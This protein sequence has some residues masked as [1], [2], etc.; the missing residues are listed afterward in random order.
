[1]YRIT[2]FDNGRIVAFL[3]FEKL[4]AEKVE[5]FLEVFKEEDYRMMVALHGERH[6]H[7]WAGEADE[8]MAVEILT[9]FSDGDF[10]ACQ[11]KLCQK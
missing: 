3:G 2:I 10:G 6:A 7:W 11:C 9:D 8:K 5:R 4:E 1:M